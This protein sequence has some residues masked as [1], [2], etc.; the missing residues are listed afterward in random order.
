MST[1]SLEHVAKAF[2]RDPIR[3]KEAM[4][5]KHKLGLNTKTEETRLMKPMSQSTIEPT[6][7]QYSQPTSTPIHISDDET[8]GAAASGGEVV[9][10]GPERTDDTAHQ[11]EPTDP[12]VLQRRRH[13]EQ[14]YNQLLTQ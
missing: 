12:H 5:D 7:E 3:I 4:F 8:S 2:G 9:A 6:I 11:H 10:E 1:H 14:C 13:F